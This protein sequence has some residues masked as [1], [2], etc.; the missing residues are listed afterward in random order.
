MIPH[1]VIN[2]NRDHHPHTN[3]HMKIINSQASVRIFSLPQVLIQKRVQSFYKL[4]T[5]SPGPKFVC[6]V[7]WSIGINSNTYAQTQQHRRYQALCNGPTRNLKPP[8]FI[9]VAPQ[10]NVDYF[11]RKHC[12]CGRAFPLPHDNIGLLG[13]CSNFVYWSNRRQRSNHRVLV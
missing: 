2:I 9:K 1:N 12:S 7:D 4:D 8:Q 6:T 13:G 3:H 5:F 10:I 11:G